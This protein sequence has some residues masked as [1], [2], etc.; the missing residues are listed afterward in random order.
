MKRVKKPTLTLVSNI[1]DV[2]DVQV[3]DIY[4]MHYRI[5]DSRGQSA[6]MQRPHDR[7]ASASWHKIARMPLDLREFMHPA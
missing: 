1:A 3:L 4:H 5:L 6:H 7:R 2:H